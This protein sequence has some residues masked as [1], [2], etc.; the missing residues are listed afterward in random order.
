MDLYILRHGIAE[1]SEASSV[2]DDSERAL[3]AEG[4]QKMR[5][6]AKSITALKYSFDVILTSPFRRAK[7][8][9]DIVDLTKESDIVDLTKEDDEPSGVK[10]LLP[11]PEEDESAKRSRTDPYQSKRKRGEEEKFAF[12]IVEARAREAW[13]VQ[14]IALLEGMVE[15]DIRKRVSLK[16]VLYN[17]NKLLSN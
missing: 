2:K 12:M 5:R 11:F 15:P 3:T 9:A 16:T 13:N 6:I 10:R 17:I 14:L 7:E 4:K 8:T 1:P